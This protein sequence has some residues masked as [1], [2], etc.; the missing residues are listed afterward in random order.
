[1]AQSLMMSAG[2]AA[3]SPHT[4]VSLIVHSSTVKHQSHPPSKAAVGANYSY[5]WRV[6]EQVSGLGGGPGPANNP[7]APPGREKRKVIQVTALGRGCGCQIISCGLRVEVMCGPE[8][9]I[10]LRSLERLGRED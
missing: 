7:Q 9:P 10:I 2:Q 1:M 3:G 5:V 4:P 6:K 8:I